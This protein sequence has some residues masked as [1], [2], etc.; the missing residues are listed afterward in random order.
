MRIIAGSAGGRR[1][2]TLP[3]L[4]TRP[5][6]DRVK[7]AMFSVL[8]PY[9]PDS[10][11][12]DAFAGS[13]A[14]GLEALSRGARSAIF[15]EKDRAAASVVEK[16]LLACGFANGKLMKGDVLTLLPRL[17]NQQP[18]LCFDLILADPPYQA[19]LLAPLM[20]LV[21]SLSLLA[22]DGIFLAETAKKTPFAPVE[23]WH[24]I[25]ESTYGDTVV[26]YC[27]LIGRETHGE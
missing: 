10:R 1:L 23:P 13:G 19:G 3:G 20:D 27:R 22:D 14:L 15:V 17:K 25:K 8:M 5:T 6:A 7:E 16:N 26:H 12:L 2:A 4:H 18:E 9:L 24:I 21:A 11:V